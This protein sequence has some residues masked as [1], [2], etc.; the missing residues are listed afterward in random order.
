MTKAGEGLFRKQEV[1]FGSQRWGSQS[2]L[3]WLSCPEK[4]VADGEQHAEQGPLRDL[5]STER[6]LEAALSWELPPKGMLPETS[7]TSV[8]SQT[9]ASEASA[10]FGIIS[11]GSSARGVLCKICGDSISAWVGDAN[12]VQ[13]HPRQQVVSGKENVRKN[14]IDMV[15]CP[16]LTGPV[17]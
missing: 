5:K 13:Q 3:H 14:K 7:E 4:G 17:F 2:K 12:P 8:P 15:P 10:L 11:L 1:L 16:Q 6:F 9:P